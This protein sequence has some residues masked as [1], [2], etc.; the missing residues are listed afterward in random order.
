MEREEVTQ[1]AEQ[2]QGIARVLEPLKRSL[3]GIA[4]ILEAEILALETSIILYAIEC[5]LFRRVTKKRFRKFVMKVG[6]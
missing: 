4:Q 6:N 3:V 1:V 2:S 5:F